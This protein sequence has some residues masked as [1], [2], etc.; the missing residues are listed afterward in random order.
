MS[1]LGGIFDNGVQGM[2]AQSTAMGSVS[3]N[4]ANL[5]TIGYKRSDTL[6]ATLLGEQADSQ[7]V[8]NASKTPSAPS[9][10]NGVAPITR[11]L[12]DVA[13]SIQTTGNQFDLA[14]PGNGMFAF[15]DV[16]AQAAGQTTTTGAVYGRAGNFQE[17][18]PTTLNGGAGLTVNGTTLVANAAYLA[19]SNGQLLLGIPVTS[20]T[21]VTV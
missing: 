2:M 11:Q 7:S 20:G 13:G 6:F 3:G 8:A 17:F 19:N 5:S 16:P 18:V 14:I 4:I 15:A 10:Q 21:P 9:S 1:S 12:V